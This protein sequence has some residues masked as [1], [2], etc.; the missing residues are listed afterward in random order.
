MNQWGNPVYAKKGGT[1]HARRKFIVLLIAAP[2]CVFSNRIERLAIPS[3]P[4]GQ[5]LK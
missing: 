1:V 2:I 5:A 4:S 3:N